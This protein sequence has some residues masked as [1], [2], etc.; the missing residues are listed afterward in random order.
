MSSGCRSSDCVQRS[1]GT[2]RVISRVE[3]GLVRPLQGFAGHL[4][5]PAVGVD[6]AEHGVVVEHH[7]A[8]ELADVDVEVMAGRSDADEADD[9]ARRGAAENV[10]HDARRAGAFHQDVGLER[11]LSFARPPA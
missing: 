8:V 3:P 2:R 5:V 6:G 10:A 9:A 11:P 1:S 4:V 7:G